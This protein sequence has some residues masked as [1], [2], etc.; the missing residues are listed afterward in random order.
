M[1]ARIRL[2]SC[3]PGNC[4]V[5]RSA[6]TRWIVGSATPISS[7]RRR[8]ISRLCSIAASAR[9][10]M[11]ASVGVT[12][13]T[14][15]E[16]AI[17]VISGAPMPNGPIGVASPREQ[18]HRLLAR[19]GLSQRDRDHIGVAPDRLRLDAG[20]AQHAHRVAVQR[21]HPFALKGRGIDLEH[22]VRSAPQVE[23][24]CDLLLGQ[25]ARQRKRAV[26]ASGDWE[27]PRSGRTGSRPHRRKRSQGRVRIAFIRW[28]PHRP[29][30]PR[31]RTG[32]RPCKCAGDGN[33]PLRRS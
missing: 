31:G 17:T 16:T 13:I 32:K 30:R 19:G 33:P 8:M 7:M 2:G 22:E 6:P 10:V 9:S 1:A 26:A 24:E 21:L 27:G 25:P 11:L 23:A 12:V 5:M 18:R 29:V 28:W 14:V 20:L 15:S 4:T 3:T